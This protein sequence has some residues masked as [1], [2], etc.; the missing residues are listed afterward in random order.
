MKLKITK[1]II[2][3]WFVAG[4]FM[5]GIGQSHP[6]EE[7][8]QGLIGIQ[9]A[10]CDAHIGFLEMDPK[11]SDLTY[12]IQNNSLTKK[13]NLFICSKCG[14]PIFDNSPVLSTDHYMKFNVPI[15]QEALK[16][17][18][19]NLSITELNQRTYTI[20]NTTFSDLERYPSGVVI[21]LST[22]RT[23]LSGLNN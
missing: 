2:F 18:I 7:S 19:I 9:C 15:D 8:D 11:S 5:D 10:A 13:E 23:M 21:K 22:I 17:E 14:E 4:T 12:L 6:I 3:L 1:L 16:Y 20:N